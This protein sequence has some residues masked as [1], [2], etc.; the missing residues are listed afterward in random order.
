MLKGPKP[1]LRWEDVPLILGS[2]EAARLFDCSE[3]TIVKL[4]GAGTL[5]NFKLGKCYKFNREDLRAFA[6]GRAT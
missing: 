6:E 1:Y 4:A 5:K 3:S 2:P